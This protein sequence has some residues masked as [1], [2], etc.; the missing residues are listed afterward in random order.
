MLHFQ[1]SL[2]RT[3]GGKSY[4]H[5]ENESFTPDHDLI[6]NPGMG[7]AEGSIRFTG[8]RKEFTGVDGTAACAVSDFDLAVDRG[9][10]VCLIGPSGCGKTTTLRLVNRLIE[11]TAGTITVGGR[12]VREQDP[13]ALRRGIGYVIQSGGLFPHMTVERNIGVL[14]EVEGWSPEKTQQRVATLLDWV[15]LPAAEFAKRRPAE[16][17]GGQRQRV[18]VA[19]ALALDPAYLLMDEPF[20][21]LDPITRDQLHDEFRALEARVKKTIL[22][23][24]HDM[25]EA[26]KLGDRIVLMDG[27]KIV[28]AGTPEEFRTR[29]AS[30]FVETFLRSHLGSGNAG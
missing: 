18:G 26:F 8:V 29:P 17:S 19:R 9:E 10:T 20:G 11:P 13:I 7:H 6:D 22:L 23:V 12:D 14:G 2:S 3:R 25:R 27:G 28:Q 30:P 4:H 16:L 24:T 21:A 1:P 5:H 15:N